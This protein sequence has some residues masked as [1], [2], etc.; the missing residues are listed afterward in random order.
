MFIKLDFN[1]VHVLLQELIHM[2]LSILDLGVYLDH[3]W[4]LR[5]QDILHTFTNRRHLLVV[6]AFFGSVFILVCIFVGPLQTYCL[7]FFLNRLL[8]RLLLRLLLSW[9]LLLHQRW[10]QL[11]LLFMDLLNVLLYLVELSLKTLNLQFRKVHICFI[12]LD[13]IFELHIL[14]FQLSFQRLYFSIS[15]LC[16][17]WDH[18]DL[19]ILR[20][21]QLLQFA[22]F[23]EV[24]Q[25]FLS[26][27]SLLR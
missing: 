27:A 23:H 15:N 12:L 7:R 6:I 25:A 17:A 22:Y 24:H 16:F 20:L 2:K 4:L 26:C 19:P 18:V 5:R 8:S 9:N 14:Q 3:L 10:Y 11:L 1:T 21:T 13:H